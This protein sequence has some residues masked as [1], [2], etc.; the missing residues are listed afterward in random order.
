M[1]NKIL[2]TG[3]SGLVGSALRTA[4]QKRG[5]AVEGIDIRATGAEFGD[6]RDAKAIRNAVKGCSGVVHLAA[7]S[8]VIWGERD[9][10]LCRATNV[11][12]FHNVLEAALQE[13]QKPWVIFASS[14]EVYGQPIKLPADEETPLCPV[15]VYARSKV[16]GEDLLAEA[17]LRGLRTA[18]I[19]LSNVF[20]SVRDHA[21][22]VVPAFARAAALGHQLR[23]DGAEH[24]FDFTHIS[25]VTRG[26]VSLIENLQNGG[27]TPPPIHFVTGRPMTLGQLAR[28]AIDIANSNSTIRYSEPRSFDVARFYGDP[29]RAHRLLGWS[30]SITVEDG[31]TDLIQA[32]R[33]EFGGYLIE[34]VLA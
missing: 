24:T 31:L 4:L 12:G 23:V 3:I 1:A 32:F 13:E 29:K 19:R 10:E 25:D 9:P 21:D 33:V 2:I 6:I 26:I 14:R 28:L 27:H 17:S 16:A 11:D 15:N 30:P 8:R 22:R 34:R 5:M 18:V 7:V 20:G